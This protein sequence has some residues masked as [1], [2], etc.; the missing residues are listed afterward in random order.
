MQY[1]GAKIVIMVLEQ[2]NIHMKKEEEEKKMLG[3]DFTTFIKGLTQNR[4]RQKCKVSNYKNSR[5]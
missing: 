5:R 3:T 4:Y 2:L 1:S